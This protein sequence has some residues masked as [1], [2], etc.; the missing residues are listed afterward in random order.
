MNHKNVQN[1]I[2]VNIWTSNNDDFWQKSENSNGPF[3]MTFWMPKNGP[4]PRYHDNFM[5]N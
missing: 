2:I 1:S 5:A 4:G 3:G